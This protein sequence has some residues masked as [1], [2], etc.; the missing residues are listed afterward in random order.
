[1]IVDIILITT[2]IKFYAHKILMII[3]Y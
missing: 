1:M 3:K 2:T